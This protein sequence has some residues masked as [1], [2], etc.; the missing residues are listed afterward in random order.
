MT[1]VDM[2]DAPSPPADIGDRDAVG[3]YAMGVLVHG[4]ARLRANLL[5]VSL[6]KNEQTAAERDLRHRKSNLLL[7]INQ[8]LAASGAKSNAEQREAMLEER[9]AKDADCAKLTE[10]LRALQDIIATATID[11]QYEE[12]RLA[13]A[14]SI[15][16][17]VAGGSDA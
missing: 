14:R 6:H 2:P 12:Q 11:A 7:T 16:R 15:A 9:A 1:R 4:P 13:A 10:R 8:E 17:L 3:L 5:R